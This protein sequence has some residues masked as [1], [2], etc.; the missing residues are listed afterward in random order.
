MVWCLEMLLFETVKATVI[1][2]INL[3]ITNNESA[4]LFLKKDD[5]KFHASMNQQNF[6]LAKFVK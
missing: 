6:L 5:F 1:L 2:S 3:S 4:S